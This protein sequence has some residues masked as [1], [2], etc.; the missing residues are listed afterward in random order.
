MTKSKNKL[1]LEKLNVMITEVKV[2]GIKDQEILKE[3]FYQTE[4]PYQVNQML[5]KL[6]KKRLIN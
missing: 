2:N 4:K 1:Q 3:V 6:I 5:P